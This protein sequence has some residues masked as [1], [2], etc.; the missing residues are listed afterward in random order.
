MGRWRAAPNAQIE[1]LYAQQPSD[2]TFPHCSCTAHGSV[3]LSARTLTPAM[4]QSLSVWGGQQGDSN[5]TFGDLETS[6]ALMHRAQKYV[7]SGLE[8]EQCRLGKPVDSQLCDI[9]SLIFTRLK[10]LNIFNILC[11]V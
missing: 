9:F 7:N 2:P 8:Q 5:R 3:L 6:I 11:Q 4:A 10:S 1:I